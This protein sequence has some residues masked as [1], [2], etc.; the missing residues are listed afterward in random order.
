MPTVISCP[1]C[2]KQL[3][4]PDELIGRNVKCPGCKET[5]TAQAGGSLS[6][7]G[8]SREEIAE[9]PRKKAAPPPEEEEE[10]DEA[11]RKVAKRRQDDEDDD[12]DDRPSK[13]RRRSGAAMQEHRGMLWLILGL[14]AALGWFV[15]LPTAPM[16]P[17]VWWLADKDLKE[18]DAGRMDP[19]GRQHT[20]I[21]KI[22]GIVA[23]VELGIGLLLTCVGLIFMCIIPAMFAGASR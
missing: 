15:S 16:G 2:S 6:K 8:S 19:E 18:M 5:F 4:V 12:V 21:G 7:S 17:F 1:S 3:K 22:C 14:V 13:R 10:E 9:K 11:P 23:T 20:Q